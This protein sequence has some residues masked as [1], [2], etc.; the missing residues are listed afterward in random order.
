MWNW[1]MSSLNQVE[2]HQYIFFLFTNG[3]GSILNLRYC[4]NMVYHPVNTLHAL[5]STEMT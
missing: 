2:K 1:K 4:V 3:N 5:S